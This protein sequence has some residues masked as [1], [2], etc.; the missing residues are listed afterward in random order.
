M[1]PSLKVSEFDKEM[2]Q[3]KTK[4]WHHEEEVHEAMLLSGGKI[5]ITLKIQSSFSE[6]QANYDP[7]KL[8]TTCFQ[9]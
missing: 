2:P 6:I 3:S 8:K 1:L 5:K 9:C 7:L 4:P